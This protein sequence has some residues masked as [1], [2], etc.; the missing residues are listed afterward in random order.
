M[1]VIAIQTIIPI[2]FSV[3]YKQPN[4]ELIANSKIFAT[5]LIAVAIFYFNF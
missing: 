1:D 4:L 2:I 5:K 3:V